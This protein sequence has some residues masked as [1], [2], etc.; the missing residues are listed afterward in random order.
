MVASLCRRVGRLRAVWR[1][2]RGGMRA[3][4]FGMARGALWA[5]LSWARMSDEEREWR[6]DQERQRRSALGYELGWFED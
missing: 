2:R 5:R 1:S 3:R 4:T 6:A